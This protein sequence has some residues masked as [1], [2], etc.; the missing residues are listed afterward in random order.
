MKYK[1]KDYCPNCHFPLPY[2]AKFCARC[3]QKQA[4]DMISLGNLFKQVWFRVLHLESRSLRFMFLL[5]IPGYV[6]AEFF[7][8]R[9]KRYPQPIRFFFIVAFLFLFTLNHLGMGSPTG[10]QAQQSEKGLTFRNSRN[11]GE[12]KYDFYELGRKR[13][14]FEIMQR[15]IDSLPPEYRTPLVRKAMDSLLQRTYGDAVEK[16]GSILALGADSTQTRPQ[17]SLDLNLGFR[18]FRLATLDAFK[19]DADAVIE[20]YGVENWLDK[21]AIRQGLKTLKDPGALMKAFLGSLAWTLLGL[22]AL[23]AAVLKLLYLR[24]K[25]F[26]VEHFIL[27]L[28]EHSSMFLL[29]MVAFWL[30]AVFPLGNLWIPLILWLLVSPVLA[31]RNYYRQGW[32]IT[33]GKSLFFFIAYLLG[34]FLLFTI[35]MM[36]VFFIF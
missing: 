24:Q 6:T 32:G 9:Q 1:A 17:D 26:Y 27:L 7:S 11:T 31:L 28:N 12:I 30:N 4:S 25:R 8:G 10:F 14:E 15:E 13:A 29:L 16:F 20:K 19:L 33:L 23:M 5:F 36:T 35:G 21:V 22:V 2:K 34:F 18:S 3:G